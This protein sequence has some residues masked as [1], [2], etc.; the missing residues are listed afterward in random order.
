MGEMRRRKCRRRLIQAQARG[1][2][3]TACGTTSSS[4]CAT[5]RSVNCLPCKRY[6]YAT[7]HRIQIMKTRIRQA[8]FTKFHKCCLLSPCRWHSLCWLDKSGY[9]CLQTTLYRARHL[10]KVRLNLA[11]TLP[12]TN[13]TRIKVRS[14]SR[15]GLGNERGYGRF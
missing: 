4:V 3:K 1:S 10:C 6:E 14:T 12:I 9:Y 13:H 2:N 15:K 7:E 11:A 5:C 8:D